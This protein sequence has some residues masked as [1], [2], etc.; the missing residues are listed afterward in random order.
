MHLNDKK[1]IGIEKI[2]I[3]IIKMAAEYISPAL[4]SLFNKCILKGIFPSQLKIAKLTP[5]HK[6]ASFHK[7]T[8]IAYIG[9]VPLF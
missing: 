5:I 2:P 8:N 3:K 4:S 7:A 6:K 9:F 1:V